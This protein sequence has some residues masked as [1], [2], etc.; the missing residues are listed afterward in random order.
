[1]AKVTIDGA[2]CKGC[3]L[4]IDVCPKAILALSDAINAKGYHIIACTEPSKCIGC[5]ACYTM[6]PDCVLTVER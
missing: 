6:C 3:G 2:R 1:M 4:C 5:A